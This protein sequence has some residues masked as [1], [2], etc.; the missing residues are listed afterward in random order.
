MR[1]THDIH[2]YK[3]HAYEMQAYEMHDCEMQAYEMYAYRYTPRRRMLMGCTPM[4]PTMRGKLVLSL[5]PTSDG[6]IWMSELPQLAR[7]GLKLF[8]TAAD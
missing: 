3:I 5:S 1:Q 8:V 4:R 7:N 6:G 2:A